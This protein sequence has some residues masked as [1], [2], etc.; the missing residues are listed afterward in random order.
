MPFD[1]LRIVLRFVKLICG[2]G[3]LYYHSYVHEDEKVLR[4]LWVVDLIGLCSLVSW[5]IPRTGSSQHFPVKDLLAITST[6]QS[7][8]HVKKVIE[9]IYHGLIGSNKNRIFAVCAVV[10]PY[11]VLPRLITGLAFFIVWRVS[12]IAFF[13]FIEFEKPS[14]SMC[15]VI[16]AILWFYLQTDRRQSESLSVR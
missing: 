7:I 14:L 15:C 13:L 9:W 6:Q 2:V 8:T 4:A 1:P 16:L 11:L 12:E 10:L 3:L 5:L